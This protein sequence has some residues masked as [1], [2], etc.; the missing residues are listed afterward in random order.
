MK[1]IFNILLAVLIVQTSAVA[2]QVIELES[3]QSM[4][5]TGKGPGQDGAINPYKDIPSMAVVYNAGKNAFSVRVQQAGKIL[6][7]VPVPVGETKE[8]YLKPGLEIYFD[9]KEPTTAE[10]SFKPFKKK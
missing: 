4:A 6:A 2:Q 8:F 10:V 3:Q 9:T 5:I 7:E 1:H